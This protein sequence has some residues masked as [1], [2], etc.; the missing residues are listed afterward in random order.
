MTQTGEL[1]TPPKRDLPPVSVDRMAPDLPFVVRIDQPGGI[2][3]VMTPTYARELAA[4][5]RGAALACEE[6]PD[7]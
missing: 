4:L 6:M 1:A 5:L 2:P 7:A 3:W